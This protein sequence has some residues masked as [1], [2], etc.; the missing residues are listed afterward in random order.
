MPK[1]FIVGGFATFGVYYAPL[2]RC[3][4]ERGID[5]TILSPGPLGLNVWSL[6]VFDRYTRPIVEAAR[7]SI[8]IGHSLG[9]LQ[10]LWLADQMQ[11]VRRVVAIGSPVHGSPWI[12]YEAGVKSLLGVND[13]IMADFRNRVVPR[14]AKR[15]VTISSAMDDIAPPDSCIVD[16]A[17]NL[18]VVDLDHILLPFVEPVLSMIEHA[19]KEAA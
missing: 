18:V 7:E 5:A 17:D 12:G 13:A 19:V 1:T 14:A 6:A 15:L 9:G 4:A 11:S 10:A 2:R 3:L 16:G 8:L